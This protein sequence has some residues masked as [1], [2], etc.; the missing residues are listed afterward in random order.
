MKE[1][2]RKK[3]LVLK[4][5][6]VIINLIKVR[7]HRTNQSLR[8]LFVFRKFEITFF[9]TFFG[10][11]GRAA[12]FSSFLSILLELDVLQDFDERDTRS[13]SALTSSTLT[14]TS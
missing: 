8:I 9:L 4:Q 3:I 12:R 14:V 5:S 11:R 6:F 10:R 2:K 7:Y 1:T 13:P